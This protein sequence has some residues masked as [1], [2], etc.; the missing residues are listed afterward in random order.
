MGWGYQHTPFYIP[1]PRDPYDLAETAVTHLLYG[2]ASYGLA[3]ALSGS[4]PGPGHL[5]T[6]WNAFGSR[7]HVGAAYAGTNAFDDT[8]FA[9]RVYSQPLRVAARVAVPLSTLVT[10]AQVGRSLQGTK[11]GSLQ[12]Y[13]ESS[14]ISRA[15][16]MAHAGSPGLR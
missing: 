11:E 10:V 6:L 2:A 3:W 13:Y 9:L 14:R 8:M 5:G 15:R 4:Y 12:H 16:D 1:D 7:A